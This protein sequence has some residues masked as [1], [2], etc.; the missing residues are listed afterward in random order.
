MVDPSKPEFR[1]MFREYD[2]RGRVADGELTEESVFVIA[3][4]FGA[5]LRERGITQ[6]VVGYDNRP[7]SPAFKNAAATGLLVSGC[8][9][10]DIGLTI[11]P[12]LYF[13]QFHL[14]VRGGVM[15]TASHNPNDW[16]GMKLC[17]DTG[18][19]VGGQ[20]MRRL[21]SLVGETAAAPAS[22]GSGS[23][24]AQ[25]VRPAYLE[26]ITRGVSLSRPLRVAVDCGNGGAG[27]FAYEALQRIGCMTFQLNCDPDPSYPHYFPNPSD[28]Q[29][30]R[31]LQEMVRHPYI[32]ADVGLAFD[33]DGDR[34]GVLDETGESVWSDRVLML[35]ARR[36]LEQK[37]GATIV[38]DVKC[39]RALEEV[40]RA[41]G[42]NPVM[43]KTGHSH[44]KA[45]LHELGAELG[46]ERSGHIFY[47]EGYHG[48]DDALYAGV[49]LVR[50]MTE[51]KAP[52]SEL[53][54]SG[55]R[56]VTSP[57]IAAPCADD[58][59]YGVVERLTA[60]LKAQFGDR[61]IDINGARVELDDGWGLVRASSN[62]PEL[63]LIFEAR[64]LDR[65]LAIR[66]LFRTRLAEHAAVDPVWRN[67]IYA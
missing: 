12:A 52:L 22:G 46:G 23:Y 41:G 45:K 6:A 57:E 60:E 44:I 16:S 47:N 21:L 4:A 13:A 25:D 11:S 51:S 30:R 65:L 54:A 2:L 31:R 50:I 38:Y 36:M 59:K 53:L 18:I 67:D 15:V 58:V 29:A 9:V 20:E 24:R 7:T 42:G 8:D 35:L 5:L 64:T 43:W 34:I 39:S 63:V 28:L 55:P 56:Y 49:Q 48:F 26:R 10:V 3:R 1:S 61:V 66:E 37:P 33:G 17:H 27:L 62:L 32:D 14:D 19:T 40:V